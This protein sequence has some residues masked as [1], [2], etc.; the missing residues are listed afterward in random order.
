VLVSSLGLPLWLLPLA[1]ALVGKRFFHLSLLSFVGG[2]GLGLCGLDPQRRSPPSVHIALCLLCFLVFSSLRQSTSFLF[3][4]IFLAHAL[5]VIEHD[6]AFEKV[7]M[8]I[9]V[10]AEAGQGDRGSSQGFL[11]FEIFLWICHKAFGFRRVVRLFSVE[12]VCLLWSVYK[13]RKVLAL[14]LSRRQS[15]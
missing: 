12:F 9:E 15:T 4:N 6:H 7:S 5:R 3:S 8:S 11:K 2:R 10:D 13:D 1:L 14:Y